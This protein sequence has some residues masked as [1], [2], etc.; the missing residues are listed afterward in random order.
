MWQWPVA[1][2]LTVAL[3]ALVYAPPPATDGV[4]A[5]VTDTQALTI[6]LNRCAGCHAQQPTQPG[7]AQ[8]SGGVRLE[9]IEQLRAHHNAIYTQSITDTTIPLTNLTDITDKKHT[10]LKT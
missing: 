9:A 6:V 7:F 2:V 8:A 10:L 4:R 1:A 5:N 3:A